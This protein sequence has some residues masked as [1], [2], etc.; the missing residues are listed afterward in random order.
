MLYAE[1]YAILKGLNI[2]NIEMMS[3]RALQIGEI[4]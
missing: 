2:V 3:K 1:L 4:H